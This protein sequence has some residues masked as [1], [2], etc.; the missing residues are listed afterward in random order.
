MLTAANGGD[1]G[2]AGIGGNTD[3]VGGSG[4]IGGNAQG[5]GIF[6]H[7]TGGSI[8]STVSDAVLDQ[9][10][11]TAGQGGQGGAGSSATTGTLPGAFA[12][13]GAGGNADGGGLFNNSAGK[14]GISYS[15]LAGNLLTGGVGGQ[16]GTGTTGNGG[17]GGSGG[18]GGSAEGGGFW[19]GGGN[20]LTVVNTTVGSSSSPNVLTAG[21]GGLGSDAG[22]NS[23][24]PNNN[25]GNGGNG[26]SVEGGGVFVTAGPATFI[27]DTIV[28]NQ[29]SV[30]G[31]GGV[32]GGASGTGTHAGTPGTAGVGEGGG[33][34]ADPTSTDTVGNTILDL[35]TAATGNDV[36]GTT[37]TD[38]GNNIFGSITHSNITG[39]ANG[40]QTGVSVSALNIGPLLDNGG[41]APDTQTDAL[42][43]GSVAIDAGNNALATGAALVNDQRGPGFARIFNTT[44]DVGAFEFQPPTLNLLNPNT[45]LK[46]GP[47][48]TLTIN[49]SAFEPGATV[50]FGGVTL[51]PSSIT[52]TQIQVTVP[53]SDLANIGS[54]MVTVSNP[55]GSGLPGHSILS[56]NDEIFT[57]TLPS[58]VPINPVANQNS[59]EGA[60]ITSLAVTSP[61]SSATNWSISGQPPALKINASTGVISGTI[62]A[63]AAGTYTVTVS[64][65]DASTSG[66]TTF[67]WVVNDTTPPA[68]ASPGNQSNNVGDKVN[69]AI[70]AVD[71]DAG[72]FIATGLPPGLTINATTGVISGTVGPLASGVYTVKVSASDGTVVGSVTFS[73]AISDNPP[74]LTNPGTQTSSAGEPV[75]VPISSL[76]PDTGSFTISGQPPGLTIN[77]N[78]GT[79]SGTIAT[80]DLGTYKVT[81]SATFGGIQDSINF[82]WVVTATSTQLINPGT[83]NSTTGQT[84]SLMLI[85]LSATPAPGSFSA[86]PLPPG[87]SFNA[88]TGLISG[89]IAANGAGTYNVIASATFSGTQQTVAFTWFVT[90]GSSGG[91]G[92]SSGGSSSSSSGATNVVLTSVTNTYPGFVQL[93]TA[94]VQV[95]GP[96]GQA[97]TTGNVSFSVDGQTLSAA[98]QSNGTATVTFAVPFLDLAIFF[99]LFFPHTLDAVYS[100][101]NG[102][103]GSSSAS[104]A[105]SG[106][107]FDFVFS[108]LNTEVRFLTGL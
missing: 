92:S 63:R 25:G 83:Q 6:L 33:Y 35:N 21:I 105:Q 41:T 54:V 14:Q 40:D 57:I 38:D 60:V 9:N 89:T 7:A 104:G 101:P 51:T 26:G 52:P 34:F 17:P 20:T 16:G 64:A 82:N 71:A 23:K 85:P 32:G 79:I 80:T 90:A 73:W 91:G 93:E 19:N 74:A 28:S 46:D 76:N 77:A 47:S 81:V 55:D 31:T 100:D 75:N 36:F 108:I 66:S 2:N 5:G 98:V 106:I 37:F 11:L 78:T 22:P 44:V 70:N 103:F 49:G 39:T 58:V 45:A 50:S 65:Q 62:G 88:N 12:S 8:A 27:N 10:T 59:N 69:L 15:T 72:S 29:A 97:V 43:P 99:D 87:L 30:F 68:L 95:T 94:T 86:S 96:N 48:F 42:L 107:L 102:V 53:S 18:N 61:D 3:V 67:T 13:G 24:T 1:G 84:V 56:T 4:G